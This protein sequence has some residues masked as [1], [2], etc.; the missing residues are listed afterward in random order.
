MRNPL[1]AFM[2]RLT[3]PTKFALVGGAILLTVA[4]P[5]Y[6]LYYDQSQRI[7]V[8]KSEYHWTIYVK[9]LIPLMNMLR[10]HEQLVLDE[11]RGKPGARRQANA[12]AV[13]IRRRL[14]AF[15]RIDRRLAPLLRVSSLWPIIRRQCTELLASESTLSPQT[16]HHRYLQTMTDLWNLLQHAS[17]YAG[18]ESDRHLN[19][20]YQID[21]VCVQVPTLL[22]RLAH[23]RDDIARTPALPA[24]TWYATIRRQVSLI[25]WNNIA[26]IRH[27]LSETF[28]T[29]PRLASQTGPRL[30][31]MRIQARQLS[32]TF[33][34]EA[35]FQPRS[36]N[37]NQFNHL[38]NAMGKNIV[39][40][41]N[42]CLSRL[43]A[44]F[45]ARVATLRWYLY[46]SLFMTLL[47]GGV[48]IFLFV[49][50]YQ[51]M[52]G[53]IIERIGAERRMRHLKDMYAALSHINNLIA[54]RCQQDELLSEVCRLTVESGRFELVCISLTDPVTGALTPSAFAGRAANF[55][56]TT[57]LRGKN[58]SHQACLPLRNAAL[59][60]QPIVINDL[61]AVATNEQA[62]PAAHNGLPVLNNMPPVPMEKSL[63]CEMK[64]FGLQAAASFPLHRNGAVAGLI[65]TYSNTRNAFDPQLKS[66]LMDIANCVS[67]A[68]DELHRENL[69]KAA[70][71]ALRDSEQRYHLVMEGAG[72]AIVLMESGGKIIEVNRRALEQ[73]GYTREEL[74]GLDAELLF[75]PESR[76]EALARYE[77]IIR[78]GERVDSS[79]MAI[80]KDRHCFPVDTVESRVELRGKHLILGVF[81]DASERKAAEDR[82][83]Y[84]AYHDSLTGLPNRTL[85]IDRLDQAIRHAHRH[86]AMVGVIFI[87]L[88]N[89]KNVNDTL[90]HDFGDE[91]LQSAAMRIRSSLRA[92]DTVARLGGDEFIVLVIDPHSPSDVAAPARKIIQAMSEPFIIS[93]HTFHVTCSIGM[94]IYPRDGTD[95]GVLMRTADEA[96]YKVKEEGR[97]NAAFHTPEMHAAAVEFIRLENDLRDAI[98][99]E[100]FVLHYQPQV[101]LQSGR[102]IGAEALVRW[103][104]PERG[105]V[106][107]DMF[108][109]LAE[110]KGLIVPLGNWILREACGQNRRWQQAGLPVVP[111]A[112]NL[113]AMQCRDAALP[114]TIRRILSQT[115]LAPNLLELEITES[116]L[117]AQT[118]TLPARLMDIKNAGIRIS[119][120]DF[121]TGYSSLSYL[122]R[123]PIDTLKIDNLFVRDMIDDPKDLAVVDTIVDLADNLHL[124]TIAEGV[125]KAEQV[126]LL[127]LLGCQ[128]MQGFYFSKP[129]PAEEFA[130]MLSEGRRM[131][132]PESPV[133][134]LENTP[135]VTG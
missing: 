32:A 134:A 96:L 55:I 46:F 105:L 48:S 53:A 65:I 97:N 4:V 35:T 43:A 64:H 26:T 62:A 123:F 19:S 119:L 103:Q 9:P 72:D 11:K 70:E 6:Q 31:A 16:I 79:I 40:L 75:P 114:E 51:S 109:P 57:C 69:R 13:R 52:V 41:S 126:A 88:D 24:G 73:F 63:R 37:P 23:L 56:R 128:A 66:L 18:L 107:P 112:V 22:V 121:G 85:L 117:M 71:H 2:R 83:R 78:T 47:V 102:I 113:S 101:D 14:A 135:Q 30:D 118:Q 58:C 7:N 20:I 33:N 44:I 29:E 50:M 82:I 27:D 115:G 133:P 39:A 60:D 108:I 25:Q 124:R 95:G 91:L 100:S 74:L 67:F 129:V 87:D 38:T 92:E 45:A 106:P 111:V 61:C 80:R 17:D 99:K 81:R 110:E 130:C 1:A 5:L 84:L 59:S 116:T 98:R 3:H 94:S 28:S 42:D 131:D 36:W 127:K 93:D 8:A 21:V 132:S 54:H 120:D 89:F 90:G 104:H 49:A 122:T 76:W 68:L 34:D 10:R 86:N 12:L 15:S 125:E 77:R